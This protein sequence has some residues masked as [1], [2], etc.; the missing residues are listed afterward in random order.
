MKSW[1][2]RVAAVLLAAAALA[3]GGYLVFDADRKAEEAR[4]GQRALEADA[5]R[6]QVVIGDLRAALSA[7]VAPGQDPAYWAKRAAALA[8]D[9]DARLKRLERPG[10]DTDTS[11]EIGTAE[12]AAATLR[13]YDARVRA[14]VGQGRG[15]EASRLVFSDAH[16][17]ATTASVAVSQAVSLERS[18]AD[19]LVAG[20]RR[21]Q[22][23][24]LAGAA[25]LAL[26]FLLLLMPLP[27]AFAQPAPAASDTGTAEAAADTTRL[28]GGPLQLEALG[29]SG[30]DLDL[31]G[32]AP[33][34]PTPAEAE[35]VAAPAARTAARV[36]VM[37]PA[38]DLPPFAWAQ[39]ASPA[40]APP[41]PDLGEAAQ[42]C[43][44]LAQ[45]ADTDHL[46]Q[47]LGRASA[48]LRAPGI[49][50]WLGGV[51]GSSLRPAFSHGYSQQ[52]LARMQTIGR[53]DENAVSAAYRTG[54]LQVVPA[55]DR[56]SAALVAPLLAP[57][58]CLGAMAV[59]VGRGIEQ[60]QGLRALA[61]LIA[62]Q[63]A[64]LMPTES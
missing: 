4:A 11:Q 22:Q 25:V 45:V 30:F 42:L 63:L 43:T 60:D 12:E 33:S 36:A 39:A 56:G 61:Q 50:V 53:D 9:L 59:E 55:G 64:T 18:K 8:G 57:A 51:N 54:K 35:P 27:A 41:A 14:L 47:L 31:D 40:Q 32:Q 2:L 6:L 19:A 1:A 16:A 29:H 5:A 52:T 13:Q 38:A 3:A 10:T 28:F 20:A 44:E 17:L 24:A 58:G 49:V 37:P 34:S 15:V 26:V 62:A 23:V 48:L 46:R 21:R 7:H